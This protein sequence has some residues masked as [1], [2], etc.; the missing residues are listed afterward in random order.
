[1]IARSAALVLLAITSL[2]SL[3]QATTSAL[4]PVAS[5]AAPVVDGAGVLSPRAIQR[6]EALAATTKRSSGAEIAVLTVRTTAPLDAFEYGMAVVERWKL[7]RE[8]HDDGLLMLIVV[9]DREV[10]FFPGYGLE[11][12]LTDGTLGEILDRAVVPALVRSDYEAAALGG[13][14]AAASKIVDARGAAAGAPPRDAPQLNAWTVAL[15]VFVALVI[16]VIIAQT[17]SA[18]RFRGSRSIF[19]DGYPRGFGSGGFGRGGFGSGGRFGGGGAGRR[20]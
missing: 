12:V 14:A 7:G 15:L 10:R 5:D 13:L 4:P 8:G 1:M 19:W 18:R 16:V 3:A 11:G 17:A 9:D 2:P 6:I 20:W